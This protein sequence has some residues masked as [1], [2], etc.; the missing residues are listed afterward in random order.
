MAFAQHA[1][2]TRGKF[3]I[4][5]ARCW[6]RRIGVRRSPSTPYGHGDAASGHD[7]I[8]IG[9][10]IC[11]VAAQTITRWPILFDNAVISITQFHAG[12]ANNVIPHQ[13]VLDASI[14]TVSRETRDYI[15]QTALRMPVLR[16]AIRR[17]TSATT[18]KLSRNL[19]TTTKNNERLAAEAARAVVGRADM[20]IGNGPT[21][22]G[23]EDFLLH[24]GVKRP[25]L[26][27]SSLWTR[28]TMV[29]S[30]KYDYNDEVQ[31]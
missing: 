29:S 25:A 28:S 9:T 16:R 2:S 12:T 19:E 24:A 4:R 8:A 6:R 11:S 7:P 14:R 31:C 22:T 13:A 30:S 3:A 10:Q 1:R 27:F 15:R 17:R 20:V 26:S 21:L 18:A 5:K 23:S